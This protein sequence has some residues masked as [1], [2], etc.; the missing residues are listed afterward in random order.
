[1][2]TLILDSEGRPIPQIQKADGSFMAWQGKN[3]AGDVNLKEYTPINANQAGSELCLPVV[4]KIPGATESVGLQGTVANGLLVDV[5]RVQGQLVVQNQRK[6]GAAWEDVHNNEEV[7][8]AV[9][10]ARSATFLSDALT[11][12]NARGVLVCVDVTA[13]AGGQITGIEIIGVLASREVKLYEVTALNVIAAGFLTFLVYPG[14]S[15]AGALTAP[16][17]SGNIPRNWKLKVVHGNASSITY[18]VTVNYLM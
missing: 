14:A 8:V 3:N 17:I 13:A 10:A 7:L 2:A 1:M 18:R 6:N 12:Y 15:T 4:L 11:N 16:P 5:S 9:E